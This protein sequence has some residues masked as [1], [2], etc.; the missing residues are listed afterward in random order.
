MKKNFVLKGHIIWCDDPTHVHFVPHGYLVCENGLCAGVFTEL[1][2]RYQSFPLT[3]YGGRLV[4]PAAYDLHLHAPQLAYSGMG[5]DLELIDWLNAY[6]Y[7]EEAKYADLAYARRA[8]TTFTNALRR[9]FT[10]RFCCFATLH[11]PA[12]LLLAE[13]LEASG[14]RGYVGKLSM[15]RNAPQDLCELSAGNAAR[16]CE[17]WIAEMQKRF[18]HIKPIVTPRF[19]PSCTDGLM[20]QLSE[21]MK[22][23][24]VPVQSHLSENRN[25]IAWVKQLSPDSRHYAGAYDR[26]GMLGENAVM[27]HA[28]YPEDE[29]IALLKERRTMVAHCPASN[30]NLRSGIAPIRKLL[31]AGV[32]V[33]LGSD[34]AGG[35]SID[36]LRAAADAIQVSK[37]YWRLVDQADPALTFPEA[38]YMATKG[39][40]EFFGPVGSFDRGWDFDALVI[41][42]YDEL[43]ITSRLEKFL[44]CGGPEQIAARYVAGESMAK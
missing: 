40:G 27:A 35:E 1:P 9:S 38:F 26:F 39:G 24:G 11:A 15:D 6:A 14:L 28:V 5:M 36:M 13:L 10:A 25:E 19:I 7:P 32:R 8:Y 44:Y 29:E 3:D 21:L 20:L 2:Q 37:L 18:T 30:V 43:P 17:T 4:I 42:G 31:T 41:T 23:Y 12:T 16:D 22:R 33:G 34:V